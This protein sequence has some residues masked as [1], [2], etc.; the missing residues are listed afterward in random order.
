MKIVDTLLGIVMNLII[1]F[2]A[3][4]IT[5]RVLA[6]ADANTMLMY[7]MK[8]LNA[9][10]IAGGATIQHGFVSQPLLSTAGF[11]FIIV[12]GFL[13][14]WDAHYYADIE[15]IKQ[16]TNI[17]GLVG[18]I[19]KNIEAAEPDEEDNMPDG[20]ADGQERENV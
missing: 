13:T 6:S 8:S 17:M 14:K 20:E 5:D 3:Y 19:M 9:T 16:D 4:C 11:V 18:D 10:V 15:K 7:G 12:F 2:S 1:S